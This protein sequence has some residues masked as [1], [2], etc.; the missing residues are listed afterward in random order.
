MRK[1][2]HPSLEQHYALKRAF[3][4]IWG[5]E[6]FQELKHSSDIKAWKRHCQRTLKATRIAVSDTVRIADS[7]WHETFLAIVD[8]GLCRIKGAKQLD[9][10]F[11]NLAAT[12]VELSFH[13]LGFFPKTA[14]RSSR[15]LRKGAWQ[16]NH[17]RSVQ[18]VQTMY[19]RGEL[20]AAQQRRKQNP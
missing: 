9:E 7:E 1:D 14:S 4:C 16:L 19:Q 5:D 20:A 6:A 15:P 11:Q 17:F 10:L 3:E 12:Y 8:Y 2:G 18:Y 13:Q